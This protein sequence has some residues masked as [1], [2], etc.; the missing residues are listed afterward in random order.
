MNFVKDTFFS[1]VVYSKLVKTKSTPKWIKFASLSAAIMFQ[2]IDLALPVI[3]P[4]LEDIFQSKDCSGTNG[5]CI[6]NTNQEW[7]K[8][9]YVL[10]S[11][12]H[13]S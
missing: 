5:S 11:V 3:Q 12:N 9:K 4:V 2:T 10:A 6:V 13:I 7:T 8:Y 1:Q